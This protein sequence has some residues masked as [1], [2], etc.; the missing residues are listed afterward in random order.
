VR[1]GRHLGEGLRA[2]E[3]RAHDPDADDRALAEELARVLLRRAESRHEGWRH[4]RQA[5]Q[6]AGA[7]A[8]WSRCERQAMAPTSERIL[9]DCATPGRTPLL[10]VQHAAAQELAR[11]LVQHIDPAAL[12]PRLMKDPP[13]MVSDEAWERALVG[14]VT[15]RSRNRVRELIAAG[16]RGRGDDGVRA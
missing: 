10:R 14:A 9:R 6:E 11:A 2:L 5:L 3:L 15:A 13:T 12:L 7:Q 1:A 8:P 4:L 16:L